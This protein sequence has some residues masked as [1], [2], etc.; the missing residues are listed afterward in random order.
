MA[1]RI[2]YKAS[3][4]GDLKRLDK[5]VVSRVLSKLEHT[6]THNPNA[7][8]PLTGEFSGLFK[9]RIGDYRAIYAKTSEGVLVLR[10]AHR[11]DVH[12]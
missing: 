1:S 11:K 2:S 9:L 4:A 6:L 7:G 12:R 8:I 3:V 5:P 10:I